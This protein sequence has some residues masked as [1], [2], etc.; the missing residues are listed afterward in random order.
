MLLRYAPTRFWS[1]STCPREMIP[2]VRFFPSPT[3]APTPVDVSLAT[4]NVPLADGNLRVRANTGE[5]SSNFS[6]SVSAT[7]VGI[8]ALP[9]DVV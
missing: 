8:T 2:S 1:S 4:F 3:K 6:T 7:A 5:V 9:A